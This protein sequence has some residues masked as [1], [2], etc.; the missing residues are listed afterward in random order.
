[1][2]LFR[3]DG[4][5]G[6]VIGWQS[7]MVIAQLSILLQFQKCEFDPHSRSMAKATHSLP[8]CTW[9]IWARSKT[10]IYNI[11]HVIPPCAI[12]YRNFCALIILAP[13]AAKLKKAP[14]FLFERGGCW[15]AGGREIGN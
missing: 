9:I 13:W 8:S 10:D 2:S 7:G 4:N 1:M 12:G 3:K 11:N 14:K 6:K 15:G 5:K